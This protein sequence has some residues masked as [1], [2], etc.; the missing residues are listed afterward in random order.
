[1]I[2]SD[3]PR[4]RLVANLLRET[5]RAG[6][7]TGAASAAPWPIDTHP[8]A[9]D[10]AVAAWE[11]LNSAS[12]APVAQHLATCAPCREIFVLLLVP[13]PPL[14]PVPWSSNPGPGSRSLPVPSTTSRNTARSLFGVLWA[15]AALLTTAACVV[16]QPLGGPSPAVREA[17]VYSEALQQLDARRF[18]QVE[19][20]VEMAE[21]RGVGS[22]R[23]DQL[24][25]R[26]ALQTAGDWL[27][28]QEGRLTALGFDLGG[29]RPRSPLTDVEV[30]RVR[31][32]LAILRND[33]G[34]ESLLWRGE[35][36]LVLGDATNALKVFREAHQKDSLAA[37]AWNGVGRALYLQEQYAA[38]AA[39]FR[40]A[41]A[42][43]P[44]SPVP[45]LNLALAL[46]ELGD[47]PAAREAW[48]ALRNHPRATTADRRR[49][50]A[51]LRQF[52]QS[53]PP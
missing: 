44:N 36:L 47:F 38:A 48:I 19:R 2:P 9:E 25:A 27:V 3:D 30:E 16:W 24:A 35:L 5:D 4:E 23:I 13:Q 7:T 6:P 31:R 1:M 51:A 52:S 53:L 43:D 45:V 14:V 28:N 42:H 46:E 34:G 50:A 18:A 10:L 49:A 17:L 26:A 41:R 40:D 11:G 8:S 21:A 20:L 12:G 33:P 29:V 39:A 22:V 15:S 37:R 32:A